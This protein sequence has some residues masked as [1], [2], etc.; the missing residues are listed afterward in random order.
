V[1]L[2]CRKLTPYCFI[3]CIRY[4][5]RRNPFC[6]WRLRDVRLASSEATAKHT[7]TM[8]WTADVE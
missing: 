8:A 1:E 4:L 5:S 2:S 6:G 3:F 7:N